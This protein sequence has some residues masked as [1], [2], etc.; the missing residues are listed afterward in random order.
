MTSSAVSASTPRSAPVGTTRRDSI[1]PADTARLVTRRSIRPTPDR[2]L[3]AHPAGTHNR[4]TRWVPQRMR[5][6]GREALTAGVLGPGEGARSAAGRADTPRNP[7]RCA[8]TLAIHPRLLVPGFPTTST[9]HDAGDRTSAPHG[10][11]CPA[12]TSGL[13]GKQTFGRAN[14]TTA[15]PM[16]RSSALLD[17][18]ADGLA[19]AVPSLDDHLDRARDLGD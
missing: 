9:A 7:R 12:G 18:E 15:K 13:H 11:G 4:Q 19:R 1:L 10:L 6:L 5:G 8:A 16:T 17:G 2:Q 14:R 3:P